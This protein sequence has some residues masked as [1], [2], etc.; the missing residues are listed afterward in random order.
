MAQIGCQGSSLRLLSEGK[1]EA[2]AGRGGSIFWKSSWEAMG[3]SCLYLTGENR[4]TCSHLWAGEAGKYSFSDV[5]GRRGG[6]GLNS[7][8]LNVFIRFTDEETEVQR[9]AVTHQESHGQY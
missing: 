8:S 9:E 3:P 1:A 6:L 2:G 4:V 7:G 5:R